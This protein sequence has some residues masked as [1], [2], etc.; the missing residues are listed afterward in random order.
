MTTTGS[1][2]DQSF[3]EL[4]I[5]SKFAFTNKLTSRSRNSEVLKSLRPYDVICGRGPV[6]FNNVGNRRFRIIISCNLK[7]YQEVQGRHKKGVIIRQV[8]HVLTREIGAKFYKI[9]KGGQL[10]ELNSAQI[11]Q[12]VGHALRDM[13]VFREERNEQRA[14]TFPWPSF[15]EGRYGDDLEPLDATRYPDVELLRRWALNSSHVDPEDTVVE[16]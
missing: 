11:R 4:E 2:C 9:Q 16:V 3:Q 1:F 15:G 12:K 14:S 8:V 10:V 7:A 6:A 13:A 5:T